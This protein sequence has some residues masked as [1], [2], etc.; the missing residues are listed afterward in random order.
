MIEFVCQ[1]A[2]NHQLDVERARR[3]QA[4]LQD[5]AS[6]RIF[7]DQLR[8]HFAAGKIFC[9]KEAHFG[10]LHPVQGFLSYCVDCF[11]SDS[12]VANAADMTVLL[13]AC[14]G[15]EI[16]RL[17]RLVPCLSSW[18][19]EGCPSLRNFERAAL[20]YVNVAVKRVMAQKA[21]VLGEAVPA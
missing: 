7:Y 17:H 16:D 12:A 3:E 5:D 8:N 6:W 1:G 10:L 18:Y 11:A 19:P 9:G 15:A 21:S 4:G 20:I 14:S 2:I 13:P